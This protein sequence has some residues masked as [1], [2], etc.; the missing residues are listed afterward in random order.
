MQRERRIPVEF[1]Y[2]ELRALDEEDF[3]CPAYITAH[4]KIEQARQV[5]EGPSGDYEEEAHAHR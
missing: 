3:F 2:A 1:T 4:A 5:E